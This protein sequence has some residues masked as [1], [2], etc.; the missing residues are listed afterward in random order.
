MN[1]PSEQSEREEFEALR[2]VLWPCDD[3]ESRWATEMFECLAKALPDDPAVLETLGGRYTE[4]GRFDKALDMDMRTVI[5]VPRSP[6]AWYNL[7][8]SYS[9]LEF[10]DK[11]VQTLSHAISLGFDDW[12]AIE[13]DEDL[14]WLRG[15]PEFRRIARKMPS[16]A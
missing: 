6:T 16:G 7:A 9:L 2:P 15:R 3:P 13:T 11:A 8:C 1:P 10:A 14:A 4:E 12:R 5:A